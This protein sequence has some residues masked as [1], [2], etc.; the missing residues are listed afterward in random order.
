MMTNAEELRRR[1]QSAAQ[2]RTMQHTLRF[3]GLL[4]LASN[5]VPIIV[6]QE[7]L[8][9]RNKLDRF[10]M[11][12]LRSGACM[13]DGFT[14]TV[15]WGEQSL[16]AKAAAW[17]ATIRSSAIYV[18]GLETGERVIDGTSAAT[19]ALFKANGSVLIKMMRHLLAR[20]PVVWPFSMLWVEENLQSGVICSEYAGTPQDPPGADDKRIFEVSCW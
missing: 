8:D 5:E 1:V 6:G 16:L 14:F 3:F 18:V 7:A 20:E 4:D 9:F 15:C 2:R 13:P 10:C 17:V 12:G 11:H 19:G